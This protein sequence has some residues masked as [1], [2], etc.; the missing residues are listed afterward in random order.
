[1]LTGAAGA[2]AAPR[3]VAGGNY[4]GITVD[5]G[6]L[7]WANKEKSCGGCRRIGRTDLK[8]GLK[9]DLGR[10][11]DQGTFFSMHSGGGRT[12][13][14]TLNGSE[15]TAIYEFRPGH[16]RHEIL[17]RKWNG[18]SKRACGSVV[19]PGAVSPTG[20]ASWDILTA[21]PPAGGKTCRTGTLRGFVASTFT[22]SPGERRKLL[23]PVW[24]G[25][26]DRYVESIP[27][28]SFSRTL[29]INSKFALLARSYRTALLIN[30]KTGRRSIRP[31]VPQALDPG[32]G[33]ILAEDGATIGAKTHR[34]DGLA[35]STPVLSRR[36][37]NTGLNSYAAGLPSDANFCGDRIV[38]ISYDP[39]RSPI[40]LRDANGKLISTLIA[41]GAPELGEIISADC[42]ASTLVVQTV[43]YEL[44]DDEI[45]DG[46]VSQ[47]SSNGTIGVHKLDGATTW[48]IDLP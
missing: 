9:Q 45:A 16:D 12:I 22:Q 40:V 15:D 27:Y 6:F 36:G 42:D 44:T 26:S 5:D 29:A 39:P 17:H 13:V 31:L 47:G 21:D 11:P 30:R 1:M 37:M 19:Y 3:E 46:A 35:Y 20:E 33:N 4:G 28:A 14:G 34:Q 41:P 10:L 48:A 2:Q 23:P 24:R 32:M 8:S 18:T 38:Q 7:Y 25:H 43:P